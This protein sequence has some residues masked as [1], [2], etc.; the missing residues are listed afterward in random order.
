MTDA[1]ARSHICIRAEP[2]L[3]HFNVCATDV[4]VL[5]MSDDDF[6][7][8]RTDDVPDVPE[9]SLHQLGKL[10]KKPLEQPEDKSGDER[11]QE[12][13]V[14]NDG[15]E[16]VTKQ[17]L[18]TEPESAVVA[19]TKEENEEQSIERNDSYSPQIGSAVYVLFVHV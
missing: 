10:A 11:E 2:H 16:I 15:G 9:D 17:S 5:D 3:T 12:P 4:I 7:L 13:E 18:S 1:Y 6:V 19:D 8:K 14:G